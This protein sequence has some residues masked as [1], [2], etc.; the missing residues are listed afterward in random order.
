MAET[1]PG[2][3]IQW[4][5][6]MTVTRAGLVTVWRLGAVRRLVRVA[7]QVRE[8]LQGVKRWGPAAMARVLV[9]P[10][11]LAGCQPGQAAA[12]GERE[13]PQVM[14]AAQLLAGEGIPMAMVV[15]RPVVVAAS[16]LGM[17][18][19]AQW[20]GCLPPQAAGLP[21][22]SVLGCWLSGWPVE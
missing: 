16:L 10:V 8:L 4:A 3:V 14:V 1:A 12:A 22:R 9:R 20:A 19:L 6:V 13:G 7:D 21:P 15:F 5:R 18:C 2:E 11:V 17:G